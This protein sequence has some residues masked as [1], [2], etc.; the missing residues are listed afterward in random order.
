MKIAPL[1]HA[2][3]KEPWAE[4]V[5]VHTGQHY[6]LNMSDAFFRDLNLPEPH[7]H[8]GVGSGTH[9]EQTGGVMIAYEKVLEESKPD[10]VAVVGDVNSTLACAITSAK[11][12]IPVAHVE[13]GL[14]SFDRTMPEE[15]NRIVTDSISDYLFTTCEDANENLRREGIPHEKIFFVGNVMIDSLLKHREKAKKSKI[16]ERLGLY[17]AESSRLKTES[18]NGSKAQ[19]TDSLIKHYALVTMHRPSNVDEGETFRCILEALKRISQDIPI[20]FPSHPR[21][22]KQ[23]KVFG[24]SDYFKD[25]TNNE[26]RITGNGIYILDPLPYLDFLHL[27]TDAKCVLT[28]SGGIQEETTILGVPCLTLRKN[29]ERPVTVTEGTNIIVGT[30]PKRILEGWFSIQRDGGKKGKIPN[31]WDGHAAKR[32]VDILMRRIKKNSNYSATNGHK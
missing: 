18:P 22:Q 31:L 5:I 13:A 29:T 32:I 28:D 20:I 24:L 6:D 10:L 11:L 14:R 17:R 9:A 4:P 26:S 21:T 19:L 27:M 7:I 3:K 15:I 30:N 16:L 23:I 25:S 12:L 1:Y 8:L 2:L